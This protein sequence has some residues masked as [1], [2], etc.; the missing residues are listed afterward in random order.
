MNALQ[1]L[2]CQKILISRHRHDFV[3]CDCQDEDQQ[4]AVDGGS[5]YRRRAFGTHARW[6]EADDDRE[7][8]AE[9]P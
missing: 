2:H 3:V 7:H 4:I 9:N 6:R 1:C 8:T 5:A